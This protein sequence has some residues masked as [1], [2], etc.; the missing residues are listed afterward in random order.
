MTFV[1]VL[2]YLIG[3]VRINILHKIN[4]LHIKYPIIMS[5]IWVLDSLIHWYTLIHIWLCSFYN[6]ERAEEIQRAADWWD[7]RSH[8]NTVNMKLHTVSA[9]SWFSF[10]FL[11]KISLL[12]KLYS[13][14]ISVS[15]K[16]SLTLS[17]S[18]RQWSLISYYIFT[19]KYSE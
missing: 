7:V 13:L 3:W 11:Y 10:L 14:F 16:E 12:L 1:N 2:K 19:I 9:T 17:C 6:Q 5:K 18:F 4:G 15:V 8:M